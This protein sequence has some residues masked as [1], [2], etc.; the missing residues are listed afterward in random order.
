MCIA[1]GVRSQLQLRGSSELVL[2]CS[3]G[4]ARFVD[5]GAL[6]QACFMANN[7]AHVGSVAG[8]DQTGQ[9]CP[10]VVHQQDLVFHKIGTIDLVDLVC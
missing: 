8:S 2:Y 1:V 9:V 7:T 5:I 10:R 3:G 6:L 4:P